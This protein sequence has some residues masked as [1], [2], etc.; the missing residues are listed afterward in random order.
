MLLGTEAKQEPTNRTELW[1]QPRSVFSRSCGTNTAI[2]RNTNMFL[3][4][5][6]WCLFWLNASALLTSWHKTWWGLENI[7]AWIKIYVTSGN[8]CRFLQSGP[9]RLHGTVDAT[10]LISVVSQFTV[11]QHCGCFV[12]MCVWALLRC[13]MG[14]VRSSAA[15]I[16]TTCASHNLDIHCLLQRSV[17]TQ[18]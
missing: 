2:R 15:S 4:V 13:I 9:V 1:T 10:M 7:T 14:S 16:L 6:T 11:Y 5:A 17:L 8:R 18:I 12:E 3:F